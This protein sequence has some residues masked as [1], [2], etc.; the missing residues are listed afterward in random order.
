[1]QQPQPQSLQSER[2]SLQKEARQRRYAFARE[3]SRRL[4]APPISNCEQRKGEVRGQQQAEGSAAVSWVRGPS[5]VANVVASMERELARLWLRSASRL[6]APALAL[7]PAVPFVSAVAAAAPLAV[8]PRSLE[9]WPLPPLL[10]SRWAASLSVGSARIVGI[11][12][13][14]AREFGGECGRAER[15]GRGEERAPAGVSATQAAKRAQQC[16]K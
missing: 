3:S 1:M 2:P 5:R 9:E 7:E 8:A 10:R 11:G 12:S 4:R 14:A 16:E 6:P 13:A 15:E